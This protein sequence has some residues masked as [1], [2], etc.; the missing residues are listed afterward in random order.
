MSNELVKV[1]PQE[2]GFTQ[3]KIEL[4][5]STICKGSTDDE[6]QLFIHACKRTGLDPFMRQIH[7]VKRW[8]NA[9][10]RMSMAIQTG[11]DGYRLI[12]DRTER[13]VP[14]Q[15]TIFRY[16]EGSPE[17]LSAT[18]FVKK[19]VAGT[20][21][22]IGAT[23]YFDEYVQRT[24]DGHVTKFWADKGHIMLSKCAEAIALRKAFPA[25]LSG[26]Y[27]HEEMSQ[28]DV[29][30]EVEV[31][32]RKPGQ[33][34]YRKEWKGQP[35]AEHCY[36]QGS[37]DYC[38][39]CARMWIA[40]SDVERDL[41][42]SAYTNW[43]KHGSVTQ[44]LAEDVPP[45]APQGPP[46]S[47]QPAQAATVPSGE[48]GGAL[49]SEPQRKRMYAIGKQAGWSDAEMKQVLMEKFGLASSKDVPKA[50]YEAI[51][52]MLQDGISK[53]LNEDA[54]EFR[55]GDQPGPDRQALSGSRNEKQTE[56]DR[57]S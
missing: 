24:K 20:W 42:A 7:A 17:L 57:S 39:E 46:A 8:D 23:A 38:T 36:E 16:K 28:A 27:T 11:I 51:C 54:D 21:H 41:F 6:L 14:G 4:L 29:L 40:L 2:V 37:H 22:E 10:K 49:I 45:A 1:E 43:L 33:H 48:A 25:E 52:R 18:A 44:V 53:D 30:P 12:A 50:K 5:K 15:E 19:L 47:R 3:D 35:V 26:V 31:A 32:A 56:H 34:T 13:Y 55:L 9:E